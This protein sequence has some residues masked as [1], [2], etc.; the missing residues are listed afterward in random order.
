MSSSQDVERNSPKI[1][2]TTCSHVITDLKKKINLS[3]PIQYGQGTT[4]S[5]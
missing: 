5:T 1:K 4:E 3:K 2:A